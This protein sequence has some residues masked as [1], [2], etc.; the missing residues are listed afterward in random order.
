MEDICL[1][2]AFLNEL[3]LDEY[4]ERECKL[5]EGGLPDSIWISYKIKGS[6]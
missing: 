5:A 4:H 3:Q 6:I 2:E 1:K